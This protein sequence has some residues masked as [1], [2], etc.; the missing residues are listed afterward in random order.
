[1]SKRHIILKINFQRVCKWFYKPEISQQINE[2]LD[3]IKSEDI[4]SNEATNKLY[5][6]GIISHSYIDIKQNRLLDK[7]NYRLKS[8]GLIIKKFLIENKVEFDTTNS[9]YGDVN[10]VLKVYNLVPSIKQTKVKL[11]FK[12]IHNDS[13]SYPSSSTKQRN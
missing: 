13:I 6:L 12:L 4:T 5:N 3:N 1:M 9:L 7:I 8:C 10:L 2:F 11:Y